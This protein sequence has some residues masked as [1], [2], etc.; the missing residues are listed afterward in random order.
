MVLFRTHPIQRYVPKAARN[1]DEC[2]VGHHGAVKRDD[3]RQAFDTELVQRAGPAPAPGD[4]RH[5]ARS[6]GQHRV[7]LA[8]DH[9]AGL[10][11]ESPG[12]LGLDGGGILS[13]ARAPVTPASPLIR[14]FDGACAG[15]DPR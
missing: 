8:A 9:R 15:W 12:T 13:P 10:D 4:G 14:N 6:A 1:A 3:R 11:T 2:R 5:R 7:E